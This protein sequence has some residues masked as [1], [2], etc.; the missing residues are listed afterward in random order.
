M[1]EVSY[2]YV[3]LG[4]GSD[5]SAEELRRLGL[6]AAFGQIL[7]LSVPDFT[8][9]SLRSVIDLLAEQP[10]LLFANPDTTRVGGG[11]CPLVVERTSGELVGDRGF[12]SLVCALCPDALDQVERYVT[13]VLGTGA[14]KDTLFDRQTGLVGEDALYAFFD[15]AMTRQELYSA[16]SD[17]DLAR[18][19]ELFYEFLIASDLDHE[20]RQN[21]YIRR[22]L[23]ALRYRHREHF[24]RLAIFRVGH[25]QFDPESARADVRDWMTTAGTLK[26]LVDEERAHLDGRAGPLDLRCECCLHGDADGFTYL[27]A[28]MVDIVYGSDSSREVVEQYILDRGGPDLAAS[29][30]AR[31]GNRARIGRENAAWADGHRPNGD[32]GFHRGV[33]DDA[34]DWQ[35]QSVD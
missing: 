4:E 32:T 27:V 24:A 1:A 14:R 10:A 19:A 18:Y 3:P 8:V 9:T 25:G 22:L 7:V 23:D 15:E 34:G 28:D 6:R 30:A 21:D 16:V 20:V 5:F 12:W 11:G 13:A 31:S 33:R 29:I 35:W 2:R 26:C 17:T